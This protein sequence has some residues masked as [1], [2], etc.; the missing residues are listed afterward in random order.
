ML[1]VID[2]SNCFQAGKG[3]ALRLTRQIAEQMHMVEGLIVDLNVIGGTLNVTPSRPRFKLS[4][5]LSG[6]PS[7]D[8]KGTSTEVDWGPARGNEAW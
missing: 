1:G 6:E 8:K 3:L 2:A 4:E 5:L 7:R